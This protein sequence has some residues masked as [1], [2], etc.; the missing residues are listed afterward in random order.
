MFEFRQTD[1]PKGRRARHVMRLMARLQ[2]HTVVTD[3]DLHFVA[4]A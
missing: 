3:Y 1:E 2:N 4:L